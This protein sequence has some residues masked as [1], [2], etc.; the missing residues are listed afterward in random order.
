M[1]LQLATNRFRKV[2]G[3]GGKTK[4]EE[5]VYPGNLAEV[6]ADY[7]SIG[8]DK[9]D[10]YRQRYGEIVGLGQEDW[11]RVE[12]GFFAY[13]ARD[14]VA[15]SRLYPALAKRA[16]ELMA[17][18][19]YDP[20][21]QRYDI[22]PDALKRFGYLSEVVQ[23][24]ASI[25][26]DRLFRRGVR[27]NLEKARELEGRFRAELAGYVATLEKDFRDVLTFGKD[28]QL[29]LT[30][31]SKT[32]SLGTKKL[33]GMLLKVVEK[34]QASGDDVQ[35]P[36]SKGKTGGVSRSAADWAKYAGHHPFL[37]C[38]LGI[39]RVEKLLGFFAGLTHPVLHG[40]YG[41][42]TRTGRTSYS[43][44]RSDRLP[45]LNLQQ[46]PRLPEFRALFEPDPGHQLY[47]GDYV[48][49]ELRTL[50]AVCQARY[51]R[52][53]LGDVIAGGTDP[54]A[55]TAAA[56]Q[57][58]PLAD[59]LALKVVDEK[60]F[61]EA[62]QAAKAINFGIP[63]GLGARRLVDYAAEK[64]NATLT[65]DQAECFKTKLTTE[66]YPELSAD[67]GNLADHSMAALA[68]NLAVREQ[69]AWETLSRGN[70]SPLAARGV[71]NVVR[72]TSSARPC[73]QQRVWEGLRRLAR[74]S[75]GLN[76]ETR[77]RID[78]RQ[79]GPRLH[80]QLFRR[81]VATLTGRVRAGVLY[82][83][84][85][86]TPFQSLA[87]DGGKRALWK[88]LY[89]GYDLYGFVHDEILVQLPAAT[90]EQDA[91]RVEQIMVRAMEE[92]IGHDIPAACEYHVG[93]CWKKA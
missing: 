53:R 31:K 48:A 74:A 88:L 63:G 51:G 62:R 38:W 66:V 91:R 7:T 82:T 70:R 77:T 26:L 59:F 81:S 6:A 9:E 86:N 42:L 89:A 30:P 80:D 19:G 93:D 83:E 67:G 5:K 44:P 22:H 1:L 79:A 23:V 47:T 32:L 27:V 14:A 61:K 57:N 84:E 11:A 75:E 54:H 12:P 36:R 34:I 60:R 39:K 20:K 69:A 73:Y 78:N 28:G 68:R 15:T 87:A 4:G 2:G 35:V 64:Y 55:Y 33:T 43:K 25:V 37:A 41:L 85:K 92:V 50:A 46:M 58:M 18:Q 71:A 52:S 49:V 29:K 45:G 16:Y 10:P 8:I 90:A 13:A 72:G 56:I 21:K 24:Q 76:E 40:E 3:T 65:E 17:E